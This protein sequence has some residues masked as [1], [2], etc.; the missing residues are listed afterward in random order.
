ML[1]LAM[2]ASVAGALPQ[3]QRL[4]API[5]ES[6]ASSPRFATPLLSLKNSKGGTGPR[7]PQ[8]RR[9]PTIFRGGSGIASS[10][11]PLWPP[12][13]I[14]TPIAGCAGRVPRSLTP[15][16]GARAQG[17]TSFASKG[18]SHDEDQPRRPHAFRHCYIHHAGDS[19]H[20]RRFPCRLRVRSRLCPHR[21]RR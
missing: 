5:C 4:E 15:P 16:L 7:R 1:T 6:G 2:R 20:H 3:G 11:P 8:G 9:G 14:V 12:Q 10:L 13:K 18:G 19:G 17:G 21:T